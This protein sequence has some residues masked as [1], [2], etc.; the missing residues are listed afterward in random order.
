MIVDTYAAAKKAL[1]EN[2]LDTDDLESFLDKVDFYPDWP[3]GCLAEYLWDKFGKVY[4]D[5]S[6]HPTSELLTT[7]LGV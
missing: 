3:E 1:S 7:I 2:G 5:S 4:L 6:I